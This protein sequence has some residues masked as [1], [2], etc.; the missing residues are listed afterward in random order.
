MKK[1]S[2]SYGPSSSEISWFSLIL[3]GVCAEPV[4]NIRLLEA[5]A[6]RHQRQTY[7]IASK[8]MLIFIKTTIFWQQGA[9]TQQGKTCATR[10]LRLRCRSTTVE[11]ILQIG[12]TG[13]SRKDNLFAFL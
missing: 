9:P 2:V 13:H 5:D 1:L 11:I 6:E 8:S 10:E 4:C 3:P 12:V 7:L